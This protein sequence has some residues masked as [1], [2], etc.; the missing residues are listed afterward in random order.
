MKKILTMMAF[1]AIAMTIN[2]QNAVDLVTYDGPQFSVLHP[3][4]YKDVVDPWDDAVNVWKKDDNHKLT[5]WYGDDVTPVDM[6]KLYGETVKMSKEDSEDGTPAWKI[7]DPIVKDNIMMLRKVRDELVEY[8]YVVVIRDAEA[9]T[10][11]MSFML[12]EEATYLPVLE[13]ILL[14]LKKK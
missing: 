6:L 7:D 4:D 12:D 10:G 14:T 1:V 3:K 9:F 13:K 2:A 8:D 11:V 5:V